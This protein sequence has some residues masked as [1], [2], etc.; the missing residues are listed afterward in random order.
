MTHSNLLPR[1][2]AGP[3]SCVLVADSLR[4][5]THP[6]PL[7]DVR[8]G[9]L[10]SSEELHSLSHVLGQ[11]V[12][13]DS[14]NDERLVFV[15]KANPHAVH[16]LM[17][18]SGGHE[19][20]SG[21]YDHSDAFVYG[22]LGQIASFARSAKE[23]GH[24]PVVSW[25]Y[26]PD[27]LDRASGQGEKRFHAHFVGRTSQEVEQVHAIER[28]LGELPLSRQRRI[29]DEFSLV[30]NY[31]IVDMLRDKKLDGLRLVQPFSTPQAKL[32]LQFEVE[33]GWDS[34]TDQTQALGDSMKTINAVHCRLFDRFVSV[35]AEGSFGRWERPRLV[36]EAADRA[37]E[38][39]REIGLSADALR[40]LSHYVANLHP[41]LLEAFYVNKF[42][43]NPDSG[44]CA[45]LYPL[46]GP[47]HS[48][49]ITEVDGVVKGHVR[50]NMFT[51][52]GGAGVALV[53][54][55]MTKV[56]KTDTP[57]TASEYESRKNFQHAVLA[58]AGLR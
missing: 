30:A 40:L 19:T 7:T 24:Y 12:V 15:D 23:Q 55:V 42:A 50:A 25:S 9:Q 47:S 32:G 14:P 3:R 21:I 31:A 4:I 41:E 20:V 11:I 26:D 34:F 56:K 44:W 36:N 45:Y 17:V 22:V 16:D 39:G 58:N 53:D 49:C 6:F 5:P 1:E 10:N 43:Q 48:T 37:V 51:D 57:M 35:L 28:P 52:L 33:G 46:G 54:G 29:A 27:T 8:P 2:F 18:I 38:S 13:P